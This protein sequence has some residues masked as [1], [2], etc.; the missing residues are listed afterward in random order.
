M[1]YFTDNLNK[2]WDRFGRM[3]EHKL[4]NIDTVLA[5]WVKLFPKLIKNIP[6][7]V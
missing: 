3:N 2:V 1:T 7:L 5:T 6:E 4:S